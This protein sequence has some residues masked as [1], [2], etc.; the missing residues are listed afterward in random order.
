FPYL[1][2]FAMSD[3]LATYWNRWL[4]IVISV[5]GYGILVAVPILRLMVS[6][7]V[8]QAVGLVVMLGVYIYAVKVILKNRVSLRERLKNRAD[9]VTSTFF[10]S[11][12]RMLARVW[13]VVAIAYFTVLLVVSQ[14][15]PDEALPFMAEATFQTAVAIGVALLVSSIFSL[16]L[17]HRIRLSNE[18]RAR[19]PMLEARLNSYVPAVLHGLRLLILIVA[20]LVVLDAWRVFNLAGWLSSES[21]QQTMATIVHVAIILLMAACVWVVVASLIEHRLSALPGADGA[22]A[23]EK[24]LLSLF[25]NAALIVI[26]TMTV[27]V[28]LSQIGID[29]APLI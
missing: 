2:L 21:G 20:T 19:L 3:D 8:G 23:R 7:A 28:V 16:L 10:G 1:R 22:S 4:A 18:W 17:A 11:L 13:H 15:D 6:P 29:I 26:V 24:T 27:L 14:I 5:V 25:R 12:L 9:R